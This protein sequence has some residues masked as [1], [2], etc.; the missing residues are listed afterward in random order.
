MTKQHFARLAIVAQVMHLQLN[1]EQFDA[2]VDQLALACQEFNPRFDY[3]RFADACRV[4][5]KKPRAF[6][7]VS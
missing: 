2:L 6:V 4:A 7:P 1:E 3:Q 5:Y